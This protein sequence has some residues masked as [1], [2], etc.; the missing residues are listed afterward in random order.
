MLDLASTYLHLYIFGQDVVFSLAVY[1]GRVNGA[2][3]FS[4]RSLP[5]LRI[6]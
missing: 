5:G 1:L 3:D 2:Q 6:F 4:S